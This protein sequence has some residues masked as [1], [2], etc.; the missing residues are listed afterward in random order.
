[1]KGPFTFAPR[2]QIVYDM[3]SLDNICSTKVGDEKW[4]ESKEVRAKAVEFC[5]GSD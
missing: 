3:R 4:I 1:M 5:R 2:L